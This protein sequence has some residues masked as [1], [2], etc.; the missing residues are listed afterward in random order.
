MQSHEG[1]PRP[2][3]GGKVNGAGGQGGMDGTK[4]LLRE[5]MGI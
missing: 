5:V 3:H 4:F 1:L 2:G